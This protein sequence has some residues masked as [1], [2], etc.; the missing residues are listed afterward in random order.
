MLSDLSFSRKLSTFPGSKCYLVEIK[1]V[2]ADADVE[3]VRGR[4]VEASFLSF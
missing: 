4:V 1:W 3:G 2:A